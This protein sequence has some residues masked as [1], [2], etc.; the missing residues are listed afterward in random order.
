L[1]DS[2][3]AK[4]LSGL[5]LNIIIVLLSLAC[6]DNSFLISKRTTLQGAQCEALHGW[7]HPR[8]NARK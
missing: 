6:M 3:S 1:Q 8:T 2:E 4:E 7:H 5:Q